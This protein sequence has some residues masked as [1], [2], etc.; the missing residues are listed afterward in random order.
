MHRFYLPG[1]REPGTAV[2]FSPM[3]SKQLVRVLRMRPGELVETFDGAG[4]VHTVALHAIG[5]SC[6]TGTVTAVHRIAWPLPWRPVLYLALIRTQRFEWAIEKATELGAC[7]I[8]P[9]V[10]ARVAHGDS[11]VSPTRLARW[12][13]IAVE[14]SEQSGSAFVTRVDRPL[15]LRQALREDARLCLLA[16]EAH[17][18][19]ARLESPA[20]AMRMGLLD[21]QGVQP[22]VA[23][24]I[25]PEGGFEDGEIEAAIEAGCRL[26]SLGPRILRAETAAVATLVMLLA[27]ARD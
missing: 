16:W 10:T 9:L 25:G 18:V 23:I 4:T 13:Q 11:G 12:Q 22:E 1:A 14:A 2:A 26:V 17:G 5:S 8:V 24:F 20:E 6:T 27:A 7:R 21:A 19:T 3:Q 15:D